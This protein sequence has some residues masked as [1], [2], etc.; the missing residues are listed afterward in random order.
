MPAADS[1]SAG[2]PQLLIQKGCREID[3]LV[4]AESAERGLGQFG[5]GAALGPLRRLRQ[6]IAF[7]SSDDSWLFF[8]GVKPP[9]A[10]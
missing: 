6:Q 4:L 5:R 9:L 3:A 7:V 8:H 10:T 2:L 1:M